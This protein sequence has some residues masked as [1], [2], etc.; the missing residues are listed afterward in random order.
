MPLDYID[1]NTPEDWDE[2]MQAQK[3]VLHL[4][5]AY[6]QGIISKEAFE[7]IC[8]PLRF[9][10]SEG[11]AVMSEKWTAEEKQAFLDWMAQLFPPANPV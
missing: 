1:P 2:F 6:D 5:H 10:S 9:Y 4:A 11:T 8:P 7:I 3:I